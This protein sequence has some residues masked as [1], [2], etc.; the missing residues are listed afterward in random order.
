[1]FN[2]TISYTSFSLSVLGLRSR[3]QWLFLEKHCHYSSAFI[4]GLILTLLHIN[5]KYDNILNNFEFEDFSA[6]VN[7][8]IMA[9][10]RKPL[11][12]L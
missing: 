11:P 8:K 1:M 12:S 10:F 7:V 4:Y 9:I 6:K 2:M 3:S 5:L